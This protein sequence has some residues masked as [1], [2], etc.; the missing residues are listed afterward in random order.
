MRRLDA[1]KPTLCSI[2]GLTRRE[3]LQAAAVPLAGLALPSLGAVPGSGA[4]K[5]RDVN[6]IMIVMLGG[7]SQLDTWDPKPDAPS[8]VRGPFRPIDTNVSGIRISEIFPRMA[9]H[10]DK[11]ALLRSVYHTAP[12]IHDAGHQLMQTG[13]LFEEGIEHPHPGSVLA[14]LKGARSGAPAHVVLPTP[15]GSTGAN[16][17][18]GQGAGYLGAEFEPLTLDADPSRRDLRVADLLPRNYLSATR[19]EQRQT[20]RDTVDFASEGTNRREPEAAHPLLASPGAWDAFEL[21]Q[22]PDARRERYGMNQFGQSCLLAR[23]LVERGTR[24]VTINMGETVFHET[25]W[26]AHGSRPFSTLASYQ[27]ETGPRFDHGY[28]ALLAD[29]AE[30]GLL[31]NTLVVCVSEFGRTPRLNPAGGRD[32]WTHCWSLAFAGGGVKGGQIIGAS[33]EIGAYPM[34]RPVSAPEVVASVYHALGV[35]PHHRLTGPDG[36]AIPLVDSN[37]KPILE[38]F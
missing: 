22:E 12:A 33:D 36:Q 5:G 30:R 11:Y 20:L 15:L 29:L 7:P 9:K 35:D 13:R 6:C 37:V 8:E 16:L 24:F 4:A 2:D 19:A 27:D 21:S 18:H 34:E 26:D 17:S 10:A 23:R 1:D 32:H 3:F 14:K 31:D 38:L 28:S 25:T